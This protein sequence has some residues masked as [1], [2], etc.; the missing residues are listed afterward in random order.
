MSE[1]E[2]DISAAHILNRLDIFDQSKECHANPGIASIWNDERCRRSKV[3]AGDVRILPFLIEFCEMRIFAKQKFQCPPLEVAS[4]QEPCKTCEPTE[5]DTFYRQALIKKLEEPD[6]SMIVDEQNSERTLL[7]PDRMPKKKF[8]L[9]AYLSQMV[10]P[11]ECTNK[12][13][14][15]MLDASMIVD[16]VSSGANGKRNLEKRSSSNHTADQSIIDEELVMSL[17]QKCSTDETSE[18]LGESIQL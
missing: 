10:Y 12:S 1:C 18:Y 5:S 9:G 2:I 8:N 7:L 15:S 13:S 3:G 6:D 14:E 4:S 17:S 11:A 16:H